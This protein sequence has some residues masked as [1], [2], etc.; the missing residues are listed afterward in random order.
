[1]AFIDRNFT[2]TWEFNKGGNGMSCPKMTEGPSGKKAAQIIA[3][4]IV[5]GILAVTMPA[6]MHERQPTEVIVK[7]MPRNINPGYALSPGDI[8]KVTFNEYVSRPCNKVWVE[9]T[10]AYYL[11]IFKNGDHL[12]DVVTSRYCILKNGDYR[13]EVRSRKTDKLAS[14]VFIQASLR[15]S[16]VMDFSWGEAQVIKASVSKT[17]PKT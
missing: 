2:C 7:P 6:I 10:R 1:M 9:D 13:I 17:S 3:I 14:T 12:D 5:L 4:I 11:K 15:T 16:G 8:L